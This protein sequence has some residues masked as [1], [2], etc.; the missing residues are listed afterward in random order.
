MRKP[1]RSARPRS[2]PVEGV[3]GNRE[4][5][6]ALTA[7]ERLLAAEIGTGRPFRQLDLDPLATAVANDRERRG[8]AGFVA[9]YEEARHVVLA[10][11]RAPADGHDHVSA[12]GHDPSVDLDPAVSALEPR[13]R[14]RPVTQH[15]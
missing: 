8:V 5:P 15:A 3:W 12:A 9:A 2:G 14:T 4:V 6:P 10:R 7:K 13:L 1:A 11:D